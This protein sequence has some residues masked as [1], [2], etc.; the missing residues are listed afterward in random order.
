MRVTVTVTPG[1]GCI[2]SVVFVAGLLALAALRCATLAFA[3]S[4]G[5]VM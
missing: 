3:R 2:F 5:V 1:S 4:I